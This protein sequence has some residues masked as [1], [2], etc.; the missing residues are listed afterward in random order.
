MTT[1]TLKTQGTELFTVDA[2][3]SSVAAVL[4]FACPTGITGLGGAADQLEDTCLDD[5]VDKSY[6]R[7]LGNP[8]QVTVPFNFIPSNGSHQILF[9]LKDAGDVLP[10][11]VGMSDGVSPP[12]LDSNDDLA[13][14]ANR[15]SIGFNA[16]VADVTIDVATNEIVRGTLLLQR[17]G[18]VVP[19]WN[20]PIPT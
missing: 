4:K 7:G 5:L 17:S 14:P 2:L 18:A 20:G 12:T 1:G 10:W 6:K 19:Y 13:A 3:S 16:Y 8:G 9:D 15:T 11:M